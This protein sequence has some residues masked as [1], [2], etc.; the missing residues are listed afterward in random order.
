MATRIRLRRVGRKKQASFR[1]VVA[2]SMHAR[3]GRVTE[4]IGKYNPRTR[5]SYIEIDEQR[6]LYWLSQGA[7]VSESVEK[8]FRRGGILKKF[9][10]GTD[11][12]GVVKIG[13]PKGKTI[14]PAEP[15]KEKAKVAEAAPAA[16]EA[17]VKA[18]EAAPAE[19]E[20]EATEEAPEAASEKDEEP[21]AAAEKAE[22]PEAAGEAEAE[23]QEEEESTPDEAEEG[24]AEEAE[25]KK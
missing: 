23:E 22:E 1:I 7:S 5:P 9:A 24:E 10:D 12:E 15:S 25:E 4:S 2:G 11:G 14:H 8:L 18:E 16:V 13:D 3:G 19:A 6:A 21:E 20:A 17:E